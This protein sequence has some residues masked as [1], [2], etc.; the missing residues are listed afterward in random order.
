MSQQTAKASDKPKARDAVDATEKTSRQERL[1]KNVASLTTLVNAY[2]ALANDETQP[3]ELR[4]DAGKKA[5]VKQRALDKAQA[6]LDRLTQ[7]NED[8]EAYAER[9]SSKLPTFQVT[10]D[11]AKNLVRGF[12]TKNDAFKFH[13]KPGGRSA[14]V[15]VPVEHLTAVLRAMQVPAS[16]KAKKAS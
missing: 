10:P 14:T 1:E 4:T 13:L 16:K 6:K 2:T 8:V 3:E 5:E 15:K 7:S 11:K 12:A 9:L